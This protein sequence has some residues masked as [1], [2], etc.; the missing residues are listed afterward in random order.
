MNKSWAE[1]RVRVAQ[2]CFSLHLD[3]VLF[4]IS[5]A[6]ARTRVCIWQGEG[7]APENV[8]VEAGGKEE[9]TPDPPAITQ[10][11][12]RDSWMRDAAGEEDALMSLMS[13]SSTLKVLLGPGLW[14]QWSCRVPGTRSIL[15]LRVCAQANS[16]QIITKSNH[17]ATK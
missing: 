5:S 17:I 9:P 10:N 14:C 2:H 4:S 12:N 11:E 6:C 1:G 16:N 7:D 15:S 13:S 3:R 8:W